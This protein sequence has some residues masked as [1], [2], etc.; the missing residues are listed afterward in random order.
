[1]GMSPADQLMVTASAKA[2]LRMSTTVC[3]VRS[4]DHQQ[5]WLVLAL[6]ISRLLNS[7]Q[8]VWKP[9]AHPFNR[10]K[11]GGTDC[12]LRQHRTHAMPQTFTCVTT[13]ATVHASRNLSCCVL[14]PTNRAGMQCRMYASVQTLRTGCPD[15][16]LDSMYKALMVCWR[17][18][19]RSKAI[20]KPH[21]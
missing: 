2:L 1:M 21:N 18:P 10:Q 14:I 20:P 16:A 15:G 5:A 6:I 12:G 11:S 3:M 9:C 4:G 7:V 17:E 19:R 13:A 8:G